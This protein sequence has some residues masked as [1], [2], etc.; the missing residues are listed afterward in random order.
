[1]QIEK[2]E[3]QRGQRKPWSLSYRHLQAAPCVLGSELQL[4]GREANVLNHQATSPDQ[5]AVTLDRLFLSDLYYC[6][7]SNRVSLLLSCKYVKYTYFSALNKMPVTDSN[8]SHTAA[9]KEIWASR[10]I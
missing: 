6:F 10:I 9:A 2:A 1:M 5:S 4:S 8:F 3:G 7:P